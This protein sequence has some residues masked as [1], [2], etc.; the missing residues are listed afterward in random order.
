MIDIRQSTIRAQHRNSVSFLIAFCNP[1]HALIA[2]SAAMDLDMDVDMDDDSVTSTAEDT[3]NEK[4]E[5]FLEW[6]KS[7]GTTMSDKIELVDLRE[8]GAGRAVGMVM[9]I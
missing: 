4:T 7:N 1:N 9:R 5:D 2:I 6:L 3:L 8:K